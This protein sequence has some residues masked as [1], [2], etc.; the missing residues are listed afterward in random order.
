MSVRFVLSLAGLCLL[1]PVAVRSSGLTP[2][3][4][5]A[6]LA[7]GPSGSAVSQESVRA[8]TSENA[9]SAVAGGAVQAQGGDGSLAVVTARTGGSVPTGAVP[10]SLG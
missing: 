6:L 1:A 7:S 8:M 10:R 5:Q 9:I 3:Q 4:L 2:M